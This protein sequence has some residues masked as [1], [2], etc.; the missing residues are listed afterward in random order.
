MVSVRVLAACPG[1]A[2]QLVDVTGVSFDTCDG[3]ANQ[4]FHFTHFGEGVYE[5]RAVH[6]RQSALRLAPP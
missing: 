4:L 3:Q 5:I 1:R 2:V 6:R